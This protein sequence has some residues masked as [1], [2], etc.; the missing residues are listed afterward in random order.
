M[1]GLN[2]NLNINVPS[3]TSDD[4]TSII[5]STMDQLL[6]SSSSS[7]SSSS[8]VTG[9]RALDRHNPIIT[10][11]K[12]SGFSSCTSTPLRTPCTNSVLQKKPT[13][14][15]TPLST[16]KKKGSI[17]SKLP[18]L[19]R[20]TSKKSIVIEGGDDDHGNK[21]G[22]KSVS[23]P[24][25]LIMK[26]AV[27]NNI[28]PGVDY[29]S[30][31]E[32]SRYLLDDTSFLQ[33]L[34]DFDPV[35]KLRDS[36]NINHNVE[37]LKSENSKPFKSSS[38][39]G[40]SDQ[41]VV[42]RVSLHCRGCERKM[43]KHLSRMAGVTSFNIDFAA[44]KVTVVGDV[45]PLQVLSSISKVKTAQLWIPPMASSSQLNSRSMQHLKK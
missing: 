40:S 34:S 19:T 5:S 32:S 42:L 21:S 39:T 3:C 35:L 45:T 4:S 38:S 25:D 27:C 15:I 6:P 7:S 23:K 1:K 41:V 36:N 31:P 28:R 37:V 10:D 14:P 18:T 16:L 12:R 29:I 44:K 9:T 13:T 17:S 30:P 2:L 8:L 11:E 33:V 43:K 20:K 24:S 22:R 26:S